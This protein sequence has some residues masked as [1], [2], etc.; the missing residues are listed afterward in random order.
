MTAKLNLKAKYGE[1]FIRNIFLGQ[2]A[3]APIS[4]VAKSGSNIEL[5]AEI[6]PTDGKR[7]VLVD[8]DFYN[9]TYTAANVDADSFTVV[10][11]FE[12]TESKLAWAHAFDLTNYTLEAKVWSDPDDAEPLLTMTVTKVDAAGGHLK[13]SITDT[14][15]DALTIG[16]YYWD[17]FIIDS[18]GLRERVFDGIFTVSGRGK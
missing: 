16:S 12:K 17:L 4:A 1:D 11:T 7:V 6:L 15:I 5:S 2:G 10:S 18:S 8:S 9:G 3:E 14:A 13:L